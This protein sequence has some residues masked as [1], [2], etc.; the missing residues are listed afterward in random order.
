MAELIKKL[1]K[2]KRRDSDRDNTPVRERAT[3]RDEVISA[4]DGDTFDDRPEDGFDEADLE[5]V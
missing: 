2:P 4:D 5:L 1:P 3:D